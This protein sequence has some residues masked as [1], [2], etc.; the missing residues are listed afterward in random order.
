MN[1]QLYRVNYTVDADLEQ[2]VVRSS[3]VYAQSATA[4]QNWIK[5]FWKKKHHRSIS[6]L[7]TE[8]IIPMSGKI[9]ATIWAA[10]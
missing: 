4:A 7:K 9:I 6:V 2:D 8:V 10:K 5:R 1:L 3:C